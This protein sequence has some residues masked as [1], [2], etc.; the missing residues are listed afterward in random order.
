MIEIMKTRPP[1]FDHLKN[2]PLQSYFLFNDKGLYGHLGLSF[3]NGE[4]AVHLNITRWTVSTA[5]DL[6]ASVPR[7]LEIC[8]DH[9]CKKLIAINPNANDKRWPKLLRL[10]GFQEPQ[11]MQVSYMEI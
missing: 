1:C 9:Y 10:V 3:L 4:G 5:K 8:Q 2:Q 7:L 6:I 11:L